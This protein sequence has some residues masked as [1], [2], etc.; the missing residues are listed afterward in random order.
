M[1]E[2]LHSFITGALWMKLKDDVRDFR[3]FNRQD[4]ACAAYFHIRRA[5]L[6]RPGRSCR[7]NPPLAGDGRPPLTDPDL[8]LFSGGK[9]NALFQLEFHLTSGMTGGFPT[10]V[11]NER[12]TSLR[13]AV[14]SAEPPAAAKSSRTGRGYLLAVYDTEEEW[15]YPDQAVWERQSCFWL[16]VNCRA[17]ADYAEWHQKW[18]R[19][20]R[21]SNQ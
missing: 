21:L 6:T 4:L 8:A 10:A 12:M 1:A 3:V 11:M 5:L 16:P 20:A 14:E 18:E 15:F 9:L 17:F 13:R 2:D 19:L 7:A